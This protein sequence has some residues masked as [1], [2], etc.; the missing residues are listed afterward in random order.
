MARRLSKKTNRLI[1]VICLCVF[2]FSLMCV[3]F[4]GYNIYQTYEENQR[5]LEEYEKMLNETDYLNSIYTDEDGYYN[6]YYKDNEK[7]IY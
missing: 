7:V 5:L 1:S 6:V 2:V 3:G 4:V